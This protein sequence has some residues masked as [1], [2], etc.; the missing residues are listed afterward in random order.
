M[1]CGG[2]ARHPAPRP[3][4]YNLASGQPIKGKPETGMYAAVIMHP[5]LTIR[6]PSATPFEFCISLV[7]RASSV[8]PHVPI[9][10]C[11]HVPSCDVSRRKLKPN[12]HHRPLT[13]LRGFSS[14]DPAL[15]EGRPPGIRDGDF[16]SLLIISDDHTHMTFIAVRLEGFLSFS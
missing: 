3:T 11:Q 16:A 6:S 2:Y 1:V 12:H 13:D 7:H 8:S 14:V 4:L 15:F 10:P 9:S 5:Q